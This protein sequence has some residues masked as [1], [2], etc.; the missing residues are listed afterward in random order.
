LLHKI[1]TINLKYGRNPMSQKTYTNARGEVRARIDEGTNTM[2]YIY[3]K[4]G[5]SLGYYH[6]IND[7]TYSANG[8]YVGPGDQRMTLV[9]N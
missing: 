6:Q 9:E 1:H 7:K 8:F 3:N 4:F 2:L 5:K